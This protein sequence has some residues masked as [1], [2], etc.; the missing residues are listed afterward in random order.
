MHIFQVTL[1][2][3]KETIN[4]LLSLYDQIMSDSDSHHLHKYL[5]YQFMCDHL[6]RYNAGR[7]LRQ[8]VYKA[9]LIVHNI[10]HVAW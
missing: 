3:T 5:G 8:A 4:I 7:L 9:N 2:I 10:C 1:S 6:S